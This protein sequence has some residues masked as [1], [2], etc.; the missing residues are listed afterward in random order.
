[1]NEIFAMSRYFVLRPAPAGGAHGQAAC[2]KRE[3]IIQSLGGKYNEVS[4][5]IG[6]AN[7]G[8]MI[9]VLSS[10]S[11]DTWT[12]IQTFP[13]GTT[14]LIAAGE[15]WEAIKPILKGDEL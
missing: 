8:S 9:E 6:L 2:G 4:V 13:N 3:T 11:G 10:P 5:A 14:C 1:M 7:T 15:Y 12:I